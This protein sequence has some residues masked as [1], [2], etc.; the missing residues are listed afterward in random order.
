METT[1]VRLE[2]LEIRN[3]KNVAY[4]KIDLVTG[5]YQY[6]KKGSILGIY[7][8]NGT[9][10]T[11]VVDVMVLLKA[12]LSGKRIP[13]AFLQFIRYGE[14]EASVRYRFHVT[15]KEAR[16][17][18]EYEVHLLK[19]NDRRLVISL[20]QLSQ[21][22]LDTEENSRLTP[23]FRC[24]RGSK[25]LFTPMA[26]F[27]YFENR[28]EDMVSLRVAYQLSA[29]FDDEKQQ[30]EITSFLFSARAQEVF[31]KA[32]E[33]PYKIYQFSSLLQQFGRDYLAVVENTHYGLLALNLNTIPMNMKRPESLSGNPSGAMVRLTDVNVLPKELF[34][35]FKSNIDQINIALGSLV[36]NLKLGI[37]HPFDELMEDGRDG[38]Q[39][40]MISIR[41]ETRIPL[42]Y[43]SAGIKKIISICS[44]LVRC[45]NRESYCLVV[46]ELDSGIYEYLLGE[47]LQAMQE[48]A[49]GQLIFTSHNLRPLEVL[50]KNYLIYTTINPTNRYARTNYIKNTQNKRLSYM[51]AIKLGGQKETFCQDISLY[52][53]ELA[54]KEAGRLDIRLFE[55]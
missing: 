30:S 14:K 44:N 17:Q 48:K 11:V 29:S 35:Y 38:I 42:L 20:E 13:E 1:I 50:E 39:F 23:V 19:E 34:P 37:Y 32:T 45:Y 21:K 28:L 47:Y 10:K 31:S 52:E 4:G 27:R 7:G 25:T 16:H 43:E 41:G 8:Q 51:R 33:E 54:F 53:I 46:D 40:E 36:P 26:S 2:Q 55:A 15:T 6:N 24:I 5:A 3:I 12:L 49:K 22:K 18:L 9:G